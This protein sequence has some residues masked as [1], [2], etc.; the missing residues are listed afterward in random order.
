VSDTYKS[1]VG[2]VVKGGARQT[3]QLTMDAEALRARTSDG[4]T[5]VLRWH[6]LRLEHGGSSNKVIFAHGK[7]LTIYCE[8]SGFL[9]AL[10]GSGGNEVADE[11]ARLSGQKVATRSRHL[12]AW[13]LVLA[14]L[15][16]L[17]FVLPGLLHM[18]TDAAVDALPVSVDES[19]GGTALAAMQVEGTVIED[20]LVVG[21]VQEMVDRLTPF[22]EVPGFQYEVRIVQ[23]DVMNAFALPGGYITV[24]TGL[25]ENADGPEQ[26][27]GVIA[28]EIAHVTGRHGLRRIAHSLGLWVGV[29]FLL[30]DTSGLL[31]IATDLFTTATVND[32]SQDQET[33]ADLVG[34]NMLVAARIDPT[35]LAEFFRK[36]SAEHGDVPP[37]LSWTSSHPR[38]AERIAAIEELLERRGELPELLP[39]EHDWDEVL[40]RLG[41]E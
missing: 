2:G 39:F 20:E 26:V 24:F 32:Y 4:T 38:H 41:E 31:G 16:G 22:A 27:A 18:G 3:A 36:L 1:M 28:H 30:G 12:V 5:H 21:A 19:L 7:G 23:S 29:R 9:R 8:D 14:T 15:V 37:A 10:E 6:D 33:E 11:L 34:V 13:A 25:I 17:W 40:E 35:G